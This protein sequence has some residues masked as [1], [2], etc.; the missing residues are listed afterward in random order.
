MTDSRPKRL[1]KPLNLRLAFGQ[2]PPQQSVR[3]SLDPFFFIHVGLPLWPSHCATTYFGSAT[4]L[5]RPGDRYPRHG[6]GSY[7]NLLVANPCDRFRSHLPVV[8]KKKPPQLLSLVGL[9]LKHAVEN[10]TDLLHNLLF[11]L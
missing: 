3:T 7:Y 4:C 5:T 10:T 9:A 1:D 11:L 8:Q 6:L 2:G